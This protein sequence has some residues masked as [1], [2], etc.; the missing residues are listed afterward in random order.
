MTGGVSTP[1]M[2]ILTLSLINN[3]FFA[4]NWRVSF[5]TSTNAQFS[6]LMN[7]I[8]YSLRCL[9]T[10]ESGGMGEGWSD[11]V[12]IWTEQESATVKDMVMGVSDP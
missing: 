8:Y 7:G 10:T 12:A 2:L 4:G 3:I 6:L 1:I 5:L 9:Q 11:F